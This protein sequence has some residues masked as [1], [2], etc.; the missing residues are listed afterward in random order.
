LKI[1]LKNPIKIKSENVGTLKLKS[2][3]VKRYKKLH[4]VLNQ[5]L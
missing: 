4:L 3:P 1:L 5:S 2:K